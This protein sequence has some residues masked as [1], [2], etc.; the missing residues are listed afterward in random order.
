M[1]A[2]IPYLFDITYEP[3]ITPPDQQY[4]EHLFGITYKILR[5]KLT[6]RNYDYIIRNLNHH[7]CLLEHTFEFDKSQRLHIHGLWR[8]NTPR[9]QLR[10]LVHKGTTNRITPIYDKEGWIEY[11]RKAQK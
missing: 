3:P 11:M 2:D 1:T 7:G 6:E 4:D 5:G 8:A 9:M 10:N